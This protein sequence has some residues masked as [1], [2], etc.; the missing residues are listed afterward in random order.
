MRRFLTRRAC[1]DDPRDRRRSALRRSPGAATNQPRDRFRRVGRHPRGERDGQD[2]AFGGDGGR[3]R[4]DGG[5]SCCRRDG[6][7][8]CSCCSISPSRP[9][10]SGSATTWA[11]TKRWRASGGCGTSSRDRRVSCTGPFAWWD[12]IRC[13][14]LSTASGWSR[15]RGPGKSRCPWAPFTWWCRTRWFSPSSWPCCTPGAWCFSRCWRRSP[16]P[17]TW[18][19]PCRFG[20]RACAGDAARQ[21]PVRQALAESPRHGSLTVSPPL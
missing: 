3:A 15:R 12:S 21:E 19:R 2:D 1:G 18:R 7:W 13:F 11:W 6:A 9:Y 14:V 10:A 20:R 16:L 17:T 4:S 8:R 5:G